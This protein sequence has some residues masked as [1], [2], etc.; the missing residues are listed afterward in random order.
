M[1][2]SGVLCV[3]WVLLITLKLS[4]KGIFS[5]EK[6]VS[7][8]FCYRKGQS[9]QTFFDP[10]CQ[11]ATKVLET[12]SIQL[13]GEAPHAS[14]SCLELLYWWW[15][16]RYYDEH[17]ALPMELK[18]SLCLILLSSFGQWNFCFIQV[19]Y[20]FVYNIFWSENN[21]LK[22]LLVPFPPKPQIIA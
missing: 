15:F 10:L 21:F 12:T 19:T 11:I 17:K 1:A 3:I 14:S 4:E 16:C 5:L 6:I 13:Q 20:I 18:F 9:H 8:L 22:W 2:C 7:V